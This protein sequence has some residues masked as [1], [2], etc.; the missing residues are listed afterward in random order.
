MQ[1]DTSGT[2]K[3]DN[4]E[5]PVAKNPAK[6]EDTARQPAYPNKANN[7]EGTGSPYAGTQS[8]DPKAPDGNQKPVP[9]E[10][11]AENTTL[12]DGLGAEYEGQS[13]YGSQGSNEEQ[14][15]Q[16]KP[17]GESDARGSSVR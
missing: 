14:P 9:G 4:L 17:K 8:P 1:A 11:G 6:H 13:S 15:D 16:G 12:P 2:N 5:D 3:A 7:T 10:D